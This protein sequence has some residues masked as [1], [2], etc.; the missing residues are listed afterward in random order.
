MLKRVFQDTKRVIRNRNAKKDKQDTG[1]K[2]KDKQVY[3]NNYLM[4]LSLWCV[5]A[6]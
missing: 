4:F 1:Q 2:T 5:F 6:E 3:C